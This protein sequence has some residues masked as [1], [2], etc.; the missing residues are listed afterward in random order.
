MSRLAQLTSLLSLAT[1]GL[2]QI[3]AVNV[4]PFQVTGSLDSCSAGTEY[5]AGGIVSVN[6][7]TIT[8]PKNL[9]VSYPTTYSPFSKLCSAGAGGFE[10]TVTGNIIKGT[11]IA[12]QISVAARFGLEGSQGYIESITDGVIQIT[13]GPKVRIND[14][15]GAFAPPVNKHAQF[16]IDTENPSV[17][18]FSGFPMCI[19]YAGNA[20]TCKDSNRPAGQSS[21]EAPDPLTMVPLKAGDF[22]EYS[23][24]KDGDEILAHTVNCVNVHVTTKASNTV[25]NY[26]RVEEAIV[27]VVDPAGNLENAPTRFVGYLSSC[28]GALVTVSAIDVDPCTGA[29]TLRRIGSATPK[30]ELRCKWEMRITSITPFTRDYMVTT[31]TPVT[32]TKNGIKA[33]QYVAPVTEWIFPEVNQPGTFPPPLIFNDVQSLHQ[34]DVLDDQQFGQLNPYPA[35]NPPAAKKACSPA[36]LIKNTP[37]PTPSPDPQNAPDAGATPTPSA[38]A[39]QP[40]STPQTLP[41]ASAI[42]FTTAQRSGGLVS[43]TGFNTEQKLTYDQLNF[44]WKQ[45]T[46]ATPAI[47]LTTPST[48]SAT[49]TASFTAPKVTVETTF[50]FT[51]TI[52]LRSNPSA[53]STIAVPVK[54]SP[55]ALD[56][57]T[58][59]TYTWESRKS[60]TIAVSCSS[61]V[62]NSDNKGMTLM[63]NFSAANPRGT[64][65]TMGISG[66]KWAYTSNNFNQLTNLKCVSSLGGESAARTGAQTTSRKARRGVAR[67]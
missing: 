3:P 60:G 11:P 18:S 16:V 41:I 30:Q 26:I 29:E 61:N 50:N 64:N 35:D 67:A 38:A 63:T 58:M 23:G 27:G 66:T 49:Y 7:F 15:E 28:S 54:I 4:I 48:P 45:V 31:N 51:L 21:Y 39:D 33:G 24:L 46:P 56:Q 65:Y 43:L 53:K 8:V 5:N 9:I 42:Q 13:G 19:P 36:D 34:G 2:A 12:G 62:P 52:S 10:T 57:V 47:A 22:I 1:V 14:P 59:D 6:S 55:T 44:D 37:T 20:N 40:A 32:E 25:P 17:T